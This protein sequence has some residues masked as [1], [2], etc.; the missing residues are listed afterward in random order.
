[1]NEIT[2]L[3]TEI[4]DNLANT[5]WYFLVKWPFWAMLTLVAGGGV[6]CARFGKKT[7]VNNAICCTLTLAATYLI[8]AMLS[9]SSSFCRELFSGLPFLSL[10]E[11]SAS[12]MGI[13]EEN[14]GLLAPRLLH[15]MILTLMVAVMD[16]FLVT[17][18]SIGGWFFSEIISA[19]LALSLYAV[20][21]KGI[22]WFFPALLTHYAIIPVVLVVAAGILMFCAMF[23]FSMV[24][25]EDNAY[26]T[27]VRN[28]FTVNTGG[29]LFT[30]AFFTFLFSLV[31]VVLLRSVGLGTLVY[32]EANMRALW[33]VLGLLLIC[34]CLFSM[35]F[36]DRKKA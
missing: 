35:L 17:G 3:F 13:I 20:F 18:K 22:E 1:M 10:T 23:I 30:V 4:G 19:L 31:L 28:F 27:S 26:F 5:D 33:I 24:F 11:E 2:T 8:I 21:T 6:Y 36:T 16:H 7:L 29:I 14:L 9:I 34:H 32:A 25:T 12:L 15:L